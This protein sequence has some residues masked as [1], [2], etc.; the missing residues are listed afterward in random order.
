MDRR[1]IS[2]SVRSIVLEALKLLVDEISRE[3]FEAQFSALKNTTL[4][5]WPEEGVLI[6]DRHAETDLLQEFF[7][8]WL[9]ETGR[10]IYHG[11]YEQSE[12]Q[13]EL[14]E[15]LQRFKSYT[16][17]YLPFDEDWAERILAEI[18]LVDLPDQ[19][20]DSNKLSCP[21]KIRT[22][23][24]ARI[25]SVTLNSNKSRVT[26]KATKKAVAGSSNLS[27]RKSKKDSIGKR[28]KVDQDRLDKLKALYKANKFQTGGSK[29]LSAAKTSD[30]FKYSTGTLAQDRVPK[31]RLWE[32]EDGLGCIDA[33]YRLCRVVPGATESENA[34]WYLA[35]T[36]IRN[37]KSPE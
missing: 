4:R 35:K 30:R 11:V 27:G 5:C 3:E 1:E 12:V 19:P 7:R 16:Q 26:K 17:K 20:M 2:R 24:K 13:A 22:T 36:V 18:P 6:A 33:K 32:S 15:W 28:K 21:V 31:R 25:G 29:W 10:L 8:V 9:R 34:W 37:P 23:N 14:R